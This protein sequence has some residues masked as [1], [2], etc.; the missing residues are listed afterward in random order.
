MHIVMVHR[1][2]F[3]ERIG[4]TYS[5]IYELGRRLAKRGHAVD[6]IASTRLSEVDSVDE[7]EGMTVHRYAFRRAN[8]VFSTLQHLKHTERLFREIH[9]RQPVDVLSIHESQLGYRLA[10]GP[11]G[12]SICQAP[13]FHAPVFL[14]FRLNTAWKVAAEPSAMKRA[15]MRATRPPLEHWQRKF[16]NGVLDVANGIVVLSK[17]SREH[18]EREFPSVDTGKVTIV[19]GGVDTK[20]FRPADDVRAVRE[21]LG[22]DDGAVHLLTVRNLAPRMGLENLVRAMPAVAASAAERGERVLL[23]ICGG[24]ALHDTLVELCRELGVADE[25]RLAGRVSDEDLTRYYQA[26]DLFVLPTEAMEGFG[27]STVE[28]LSTNRPVVGTPAGATPEILESIEGCIV[29]RDTSASAISDA[30]VEWLQRPDRREPT[31]RYRDTVLAKY[32][33]ERVTDAL[34]AYYQ[35]QARAFAEQNGH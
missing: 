15:W 10:V 24:G 16:E 13:T 17:Y 25:V 2:M 9:R 21:R 18:I 1:G 5:Y 22:L 29:S 34:E 20:R 26:A 7:F 35:E 30:V 4:G 14:E 11:L 8:P 27:I 3:P 33:W 19:P 23:T 12:R 32:D 6:V 31:T 28:A